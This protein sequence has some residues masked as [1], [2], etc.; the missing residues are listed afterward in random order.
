MNTRSTGSM[1]GREAASPLSN[2]V[3]ALVAALPIGIVAN[4]LMTIVRARSEA[5]AVLPGKRLPAQSGLSRG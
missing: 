5:R 4:A 3:A 2:E 1:I